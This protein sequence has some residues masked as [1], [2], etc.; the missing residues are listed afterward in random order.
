MS[1][2]RFSET[3]TA[4]TGSSKVAQAKRVVAHVK[5]MQA[6]LN[7][8]DT[9]VEKVHKAFQDV[10][11]TYTKSQVNKVISACIKMNN[12]LSSYVKASYNGLKV[13]VHMG[14]PT[15]KIAT[16]IEDMMVLKGKIAILQAQAAASI[17][18]LADI[19]EDIVQMDETGYAVDNADPVE[20]IVPDEPMTDETAGVEEEPIDPA[21]INPSASR[22][23]EEIP[24]DFTEV[25]DDQ[26]EEVTG[27]DDEFVD[28]ESNTDLPELAFDDNNDTE[29]IISN[30]ILAPEDMQALGCDD[31]E[32][33]NTAPVS[34]QARKLA[35]SRST[36]GRIAAN[37]G[38]EDALLKSLAAEL[39]Q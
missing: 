7:S 13:A 23:G 16:Q 20:N 22:R 29:D 39:L 30:E 36:N 10:K 35:S 2:R 3:T 12:T 21:L 1:I 11:A 33:E 31:E 27:E 17:G 6:A 28:D 25:T 18:Y 37:S 32:M 14:L 38:S 34:A 24:E 8:V 4:N 5:N 19:D 9:T 15:G 26:N